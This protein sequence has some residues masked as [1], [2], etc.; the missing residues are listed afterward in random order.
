MDK[1]ASDQ[2]RCEKLKAASL[3]FARD[4]SDRPRPASVILT[5]VTSIVRLPSYGPGCDFSE[6]VV[7]K[8]YSSSNVEPCP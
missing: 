4:A 7:D 5:R 1:L 2:L 3:P 8:T 6:S